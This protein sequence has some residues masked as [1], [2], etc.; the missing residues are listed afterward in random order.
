[1]SQ[2]QKGAIIGGVFGAFAC[3]AIAGAVIAWLF[4][5]KRKRKRKRKRKEKEIIN[6][7]KLKK[8]FFFWGLLICEEHF[9]IN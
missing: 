1:M 8:N 9:K 3:I 4:I 2:S 7:E 5:K 6:K